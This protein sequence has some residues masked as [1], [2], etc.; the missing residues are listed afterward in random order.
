TAGVECKVLVVTLFTIVIPAWRH[1]PGV[2]AV[3]VTFL[4]ARNRRLVPR[5]A[6]VDRIA[7]RILADESLALFPVFVV[8][9]AEQNANAE[10]DIDQISRDELS[11]NDHTGR[12][13][14]RVAPFVHVLVGVVADCRIL[15][16]SPATEQ[17]ATLTNFLVTRQRLVNEV[18]EIVV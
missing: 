16:R 8:R 12:H 11:V 4:W 1:H 5:M 7:E 13:V 3:K 10:I 2:F 14:H 18:E 15:E 6:F 9:T 17:D